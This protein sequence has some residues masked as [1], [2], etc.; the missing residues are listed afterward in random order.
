MKKYFFPLF[1]VF[2]FCLLL[3]ISPSLGESTPV[4]FDSKL[5][6]SVSDQIQEATDLTLTD[7]SRA[8]LAALLTLEY[9]VQEPD[10]KIDFTSPIFVSKSGTT[11]RING[12]GCF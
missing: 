5:M 3:F 10:I 9:Q 8:V 4:Q 2:A 7:D 11:C 12:T 1:F 6:V